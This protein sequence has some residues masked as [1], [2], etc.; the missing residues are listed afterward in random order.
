M[1]KMVI[2]AK[3]IGEVLRCPNMIANLAVHRRR[4][5][6]SRRWVNANDELEATAR[7]ETRCCRRAPAS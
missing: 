3:D 4:F 1:L 7:G 5:N 2:F 6:L